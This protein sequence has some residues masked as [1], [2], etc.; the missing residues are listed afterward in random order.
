VR[1]GVGAAVAIAVLTTA[2]AIARPE[3]PF[4]TRNQSLHAAVETAAACIALLATLLAFG[5]FQ[6]GRYVRDLVLGAAFLLFGLTNL[7]FAVVPTVVAGYALD[8]Y[9]TWAAL[10][11]RGAAAVLLCNAALM[12]ARR[13]HHRSASRWAMGAVL[14][15]LGAVAGVVAVTADRLPE[16]VGLVG[17]DPLGFTAPVTY[18]A[19]TTVQAV[20]FILYGLAVI[21]FARRAVRER[22]ELSA[23]F[24]AATG[25][26]AAAR[27][28]FVL[29]PSLYAQVVYSG[30][31]LRLGFYLLVFI[32]SAREL[33]RYWQQL[34][35]VA[36]IDERRR[37]A[38]DLHDGVAQELAFIATQ[39]GRRHRPL[40]EDERL[41][42]IASAARRGLD[43]S[44][45][46]IAAL[47]EREDQTLDAAV[48]QSVEEVAARSGARA[49]FDLPDQVE[50][51]AWLREELVRVTREAVTNATRH[52]RSNIV[53]V[54]LTVNEEL[55]LEIRDEGTGF[56]P[57]SIRG[58]FG[59]VGMRERVDALGGRLRIRSAPGEGTEVQVVVPWNDRSDS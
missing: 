55:C 7:L 25:L 10:A 45:R 23:W 28:H 11:G 33:A 31:V 34:S 46:A 17:V 32:G 24:A 15:Y 9:D 51:G 37:L 44:R 50:V 41:R 49:S 57:D 2:L 48:A 16:G 43:E 42:V 1:I 4:A 38:R 14:A 58:G 29:Y 19:I 21:G 22:D 26:A 18:P 12:P 5:R 13:A 53:H 35:E 36:V 54:R 59:L 52:G 20:V 30:D 56:D 6:R 40:D 39:A 47:S 8:A 3:L 27:V